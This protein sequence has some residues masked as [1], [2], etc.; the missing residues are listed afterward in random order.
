MYDP[1][2][3]KTIPNTFERPEGIW[4]K[5][6]Q[7]KIY[8]A[9][10]QDIKTDTV[11]IGGG[12][13]GLSCAYHLAKEFQIDCVVV[14]ANQPGWGCSGRNGGFVLPGTGRLNTQ[15][16]S[17]R[18][19]KEAAKSIY[20]EYLT[21]IDLVKSFVDLGI[22]CDLTE[23]GYLK[24]AHAQHLVEPLHKQAR[25]LSQDYG[26]SIVPLNKV[27]VRDHYLQ[28]A[29]SFG[30][31]FYPD[32]FGVNPWKLC[33]GVAGLANQQGAQIFGNSPVLSCVKE[34]T[35]HRITT[36]QGSIKAKHLVIATNAYTQPNLHPSLKNRMFPVLSS[37]IVTKPLSPAKL[38]EIGMRQGLMVMD[39]R[40]L[41][42]YY[43]ILPDNRLLFGGRGAIQGA[44]ANDQKYKDALQKGLSETFPE[45]DKLHIDSFWSG[46]VSVS[47]DDFPR[48]HH[49]KSI[50]TLYSGGYCGAGLAF[51]L[52]AGKRL[53]QLIGAPAE[54]PAL[55][56][57]ASPLRKFPLAA[58]RRPALQGF[59]WY[60]GI[61]RG[62]GV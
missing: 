54:V 22:N 1:L 23:G 46:W 26:D 41:K 9:L 36:P 51:S 7:A 62:L 45:L 49:D 16:L 4:A 52:Q 42:Y 44:K 27:Q 8:S 10:S 61:K 32:A 17:K 25:L 37:I 40:S 21:S 58:L 48:V 50:N 18:W 5:N 24:L 2:V 55:P 28:G 59:Y 31:I 13:T 34:G 3:N 60:Q 39:T 38:S 20:Q 15:Q 6:Q 35:E 11:I 57:M 12:Y 19:G 29:A 30:G 43:R 56:F 33:N 53:A 14:E 47:Y